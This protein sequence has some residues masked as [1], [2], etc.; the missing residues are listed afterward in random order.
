M[1]GFLAFVGSLA[2]LAT[3]L[4]AQADIAYAVGSILDGGSHIY[5]IDNFN[6]TPTA[7]VLA[8]SG[9]YLGDI[10]VH[11]TSGTAYAIASHTGMLHMV[12]LNTGD[13]TLVGDTGVIGLNSLEVAPNGTIYARAYDSDGLWS[14]DPNTG[15]ATLLVE[16]DFGGGSDLA[17]APNGTDLYATASLGDGV[18][19]ALIRIDLNSMNV[20]SIGSFGQNP[21]LMPGLDFDSNGNLYAFAGQDNSGLAQVYHVDMATGAATLIDSIAGAQDLG[22]LG[23]TIAIPEPASLSLVG[24]GLAA[25]LRRRR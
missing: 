21:L 2:V 18:G 17:L 4:P 1:R 6:S 9:T 3:A 16:T 24:I 20:V 19:T 14:L 23:A 10:A 11:P 22:L 25:L 12:D 8:D 7:T 5:R 13:L 15:A